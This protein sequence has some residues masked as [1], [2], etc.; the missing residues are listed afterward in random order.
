MT[1]DKRKHVTA[2]TDPLAHLVLRDPRTPEERQAAEA[3]ERA[4]RKGRK[5]R[6]WWQETAPDGFTG[7]GVASQLSRDRSS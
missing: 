6:G 5:R 2:A 1:D 4:R 7:A 3:K